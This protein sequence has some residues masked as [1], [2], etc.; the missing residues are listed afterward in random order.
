MV[1]NSS[2]LYFLWSSIFAGQGQDQ[3]PVHGGGGPRRLGEGRGVAVQRH[4]RPVGLSD[5]PLRPEIAPRVRNRLDLEERQGQL[6]AHHREGRQGV[7][8]PR[9]PGPPRR[10]AGEAEEGMEPLVGRRRLLV[11]GELGGDGTVLHHLRHRH[12]SCVCRS[13]RRIANGWRRGRGQNDPSEGGDHLWGTS[14]GK[15]KRPSVC[16]CVCCVRMCIC[17]Y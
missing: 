17:I 5:R 10:Q 11:E 3:Q 12:S 1:P 13:G 8:A 15:S 6:R 14:F 16:L 7:D 2:S 9:V 4:P